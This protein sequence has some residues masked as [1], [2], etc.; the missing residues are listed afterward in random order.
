MKV[1]KFRRKIK[2][3]RHQSVERS[4][5]QIAAIQLNPHTILTLM[6]LDLLVLARSSL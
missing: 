1:E 5:V 4:G 3:Q 6:K 2:T